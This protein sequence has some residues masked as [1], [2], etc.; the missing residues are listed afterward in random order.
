MNLP[1][2]LALIVASAGLAVPQAAFAKPMMPSA[3]WNGTWKLDTAESKF[4]T[5]VG[6]RSE[7]RTYKITGNKLSLKSEGKDADGKP[8]GFSYSGAYDGKWYPMKGNPRGDSIALT[9]ASPRVAKAKVRKNG[10]L[11]V[12]GTLTVSPDGKT[13]TLNRQTLRAKGSPITEVLVF[14]RAD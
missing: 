3:Q 13:L 2:K 12:T 7:T 6:K 5:P 1:I 14:D 9:L 10:K 8:E 11:T 4:A